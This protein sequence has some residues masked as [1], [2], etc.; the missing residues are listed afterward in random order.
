MKNLISAIAATGAVLFVTSASAQDDAGKKSPAI[1][2]PALYEMKLT[3]GRLTGPGAK[4]IRARLPKAQ[5]VLVGEEH[6]FAAGPRLAQALAR[7]GR[8]HGLVHHVVETGPVSEEWATEILNQGGWPALGRALKDRPLALPFLSMRED[9]ELARYFLANAPS[10]ADVLWGVDQEFIGSPLL[11]FETL[12][13]IAP[14]EEAKELAETLLAAERKA[15]ADGKQDALFLFSAGEQDFAELRSAF[16]ESRESAEIIDAL[17]ESAAI[18]QA[19]GQGKNYASNAE[20]IE[21]IRSQFLE[22]YREAPGEAPRV[23]FK[24]GA[25]H[26]GRGTTFLNTFD[27]GSLTEG[28]AA[29]NGLDVLRVLYMPLSGRY[30][31]MTPFSESA[32]AMPNMTG[33]KFAKRSRPSGSRRT[34]WRKRA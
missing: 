30:A 16:G 4:L 26:L 32:F 2:P 15:F 14:D 8:E 31:K 12:A 28:I 11:H 13:G 1:E 22:A 18:Y 9:A 7:A 27:L 24:M 10:D 34:W 25:I 17:E 19:F 23:L 20:R 5:F 21:L 3:D 6:G 33:R 29:A